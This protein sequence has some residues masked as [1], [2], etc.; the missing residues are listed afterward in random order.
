MH[1]Q[2]T[3]HDAEQRRQQIVEPELPRGNCALA[4]EN[5]TQPP[6]EHSGFV[7]KELPLHRETRLSHFGFQLPACIT[8]EV[9][10]LTIEVAVEFWI[11]WHQEYKTGI[12]CQ[13]LI[14]PLQYERLI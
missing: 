5:I 7:E 6:G 3:I 4:E 13:H 1:R 9:T 2:A 11:E 8:P 14:Q 12:C 10:D